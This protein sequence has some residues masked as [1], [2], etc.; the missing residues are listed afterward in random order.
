MWIFQYWKVNSF[1]VQKYFFDLWNII[2]IRQYLPIVYNW[3]WYLSAVWYRWCTYT[4]WH[5]VELILHYFDWGLVTLS[6]FCFLLGFSLC[7]TSFLNKFVSE[8]QSNKASVSM[9]VCRY[10]RFVGM[11]SNCSSIDVNITGSHFGRNCLFSL[12]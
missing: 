2:S 11:I 1:Q 9:K 3:S 4:E 10:E 12:Y 8:Q 5:I 6:L 7:T